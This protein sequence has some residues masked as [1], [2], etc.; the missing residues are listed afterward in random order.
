MKKVLL[1]WGSW[2]KKKKITGKKLVMALSSLILAAMVCLCLFV[3]VQ[4][5]GK[6]YVSIG[7]YSM[8]RVVTG[9]MEPEISVGAVL[10]NHKV[11]LEA[12]EPG[13]IICFQGKNPELQGAIVTHRVMEVH[14]AG[15]GQI[16]LETKGDANLAVDP[17]YA[18]QSNFI[19]KVVWHSGN[20]H[21]TDFLGFLN[22]KGGFVLCILFPV[23]LVAGIVLQS[24]VRT[25]GRDLKTLR[26]QIRE[27][28]RKQQVLPGYTYLTYEDYEEI[29]QSLKASLLGE[30]HETK[31]E[32]DGKME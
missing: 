21:F 2:L 15:N 17:Y 24:S 7:G 22:E 26:Q 19:G 16:Y 27:E 25:L 10:L 28:S 3:S 9:S 1:T 14:T 32:S 6:G 29:Y 12:I 20:N 5:A 4:V 8:F 31:K 13:D 30:M 23:L 11:P 18:D